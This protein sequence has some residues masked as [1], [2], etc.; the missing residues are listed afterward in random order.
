MAG[1]TRLI[2]HRELIAQTEVTDFYRV[3]PHGVMAGTFGVVFLMVVTAMAISIARFVKHARPSGSAA[4]GRSIVAGL[5]D[6]L[7]LKYLHNAGDDCA[8]E[9]DIRAPWRRFC[10]HLTFY[11]FLLCFASTTV[12]ASYSVFMNWN[13]PYPFFSIPVL[14]GTSGGIGLVVGPV[15]LWALRVRR[16]LA[17][18]DSAQTGLDLGFILMLVLTSVTGLALLAFRDSAQ[19][20]ILL[21]VHLAFVLTLFVTLPY[22][23]FMHGLYRMAAL[24]QFAHESQDE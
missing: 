24:I 16:D 21:I 20:G 19:M 3:I 23:K 9:E 7:T 6:A 2:L 11:G 4:T 13:A 18:M 14:L 12:A 17:T 15:G 8:I 10:H 5:R 1:A 22:G